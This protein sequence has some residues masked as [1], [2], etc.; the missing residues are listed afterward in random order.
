MSVNLDNFA[1]VICQHKK[2]ED[3]ILQNSNLQNLCAKYLTKCKKCPP[4]P[5]NRR[6]KAKAYCLCFAIIVYLDDD[7]GSPKS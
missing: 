1:C 5:T 7:N 6:Q 4:K 3:Q 2:T